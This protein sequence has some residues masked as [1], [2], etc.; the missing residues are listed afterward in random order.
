MIFPQLRNCEVASAGR[1]GAISAVN[2]SRYTDSET[3]VISQQKF[4][5][6]RVGCAK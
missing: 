1:D 6:G 2:P 3:D 5:K 4:S